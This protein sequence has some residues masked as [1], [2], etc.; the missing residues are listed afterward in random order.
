[1]PL[2]LPTDTQHISLRT[3]QY[4]LFGRS[5]GQG[6]ERQSL[7]IAAIA[8]IVWWTLLIIIGVPLLTRFS[9]LVYLVPPAAFVINSTRRDDTGRIVLVRWWD[10]L[11]SKRPSRRRTITNPLL[12]LNRPAPLV[13]RITVASELVHG[14][15]DLGKGEPR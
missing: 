9:P 10:W 12:E 7:L 5:L 14:P 3:R 6:V 13:L 2:R 1:M 11:L 4:E 15:D 8:V